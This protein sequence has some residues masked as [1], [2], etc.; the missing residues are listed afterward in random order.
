MGL[1]LNTERYAGLLAEHAP[2]RIDSQSE[3]DQWAN[4]LEVIRFNEPSKPDEGALGDPIT[5][6]LEDFDRRNHPDFS[7]Q[8]RLACCTT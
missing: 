4:W 6:L 2:R 8:T 3:N 1:T 5:I 7:L